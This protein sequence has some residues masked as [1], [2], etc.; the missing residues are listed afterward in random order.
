M[1][2]HDAVLPMHF[3]DLTPEEIAS[4][5]SMHDLMVVEKSL[6]STPFP[7]SSIVGFLTA[8]KGLPQEI[9]PQFFFIRAADYYRFLREFIKPTNDAI[10]I[11]ALG[12]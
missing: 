8:F 10:H 4:F 6:L 3:Y 2:Y 5:K 11:I 1:P 9:Q 12:W 7:Q